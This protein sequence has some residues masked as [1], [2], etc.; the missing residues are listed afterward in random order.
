MCAFFVSD[1]VLD[2]PRNHKCLLTHNLPTLL[3]ASGLEGEDNV[4]ASKAG[5]GKIMGQGILFRTWNLPHGS[6][7]GVGMASVS[8]PS[9][10]EI[11]KLGNCMPAALIFP[12]GIMIE[13]RYMPDCW[14]L[15]VDYANIKCINRCCISF[16]LTEEQKK[17]FKSRET[18]SVP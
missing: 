8:I 15:R 4:D 1:A 2:V 13:Y 6:A 14:Q 3:T 18:K 17:A 11:A 10:E 12:L 16:L 5:R 9:P 7:G